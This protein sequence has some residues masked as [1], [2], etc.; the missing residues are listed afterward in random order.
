M[1]PSDVQSEAEP[2][3]FD[4]EE[5]DMSEQQFASSL[6]DSREKPQFEIDEAEQGSLLEETCAAELTAAEDRPFA[7]GGST[8][9]ASSDFDAITEEEP[10]TAREPGR[11]P[12]PETAAEPDWRRMVSA[13]VNSYKA[14]NPQQ[15]RYPS[16]RLQFD[17][18]PGKTSRQLQ[19]F[20]PVEEMGSTVEQAAEE[21]SGA[22]LAPPSPLPGTS[23]RVVMEA[24]ARVIE[25]PRPAIGADELAEPV[26]DRPRIVEAPE[27]LPPPPAMGGILIEE[28]RETEPERRPGFDFPLQSATLN[29]RVAA[30][31]F[32]ASLV[33]AALVLFAYVF[34]RINGGMPP[35]RLGAVLASCLLVILWPAYQYA[36][37]V[38]CGKTPGLWAAKLHLA[39]FNGQPA[40]RSLRR[41]R[42]LASVLSLV[43]LGL[44]YAW[45]LLDED[46]LSWH[47]RITRTHLAPR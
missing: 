37:L 14:R 22:V 8:T 28:Q 47:D 31:L 9:A 19:A 6:D 10:G 29:R 44:G 32:D 41:W 45:C 33:M 1:N 16:L 2:R 43:S 13:K 21:D 34:L 25:F 42:V 39:S 7:R 4:P 35:L 18:P 23:T 36:F 27:L 24:T 46:Q 40:A 30:G 11:D 38:Y 12:S 15:E 5:L 3:Y 17:P 20:A 26:I